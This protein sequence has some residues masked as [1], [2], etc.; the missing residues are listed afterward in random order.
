[1]ANETRPAYHGWYKL[2]IWHKRL[3]PQ[4]LAK[5][6]LCKRCLAEGKITAATVVDHIIPHKGD[7]AGFTDPE[8]LQSLCAHHHNS[9][10]QSIDRTGYSKAVGGDGWPTDPAHPANRGAL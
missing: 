2:A 6:P 7:W 9:A 10:K 1:M 4:Q 5:E 8:N 3:R